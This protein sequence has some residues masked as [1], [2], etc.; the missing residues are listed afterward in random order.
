M[1]FIITFIKDNSC[2][3]LRTIIV[4]IKTAVVKNVSPQKMEEVDAAFE[5]EDVTTIFVKIG[6]CRLAK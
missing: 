1:L 2:S 3:F 4:E 6:K 5:S